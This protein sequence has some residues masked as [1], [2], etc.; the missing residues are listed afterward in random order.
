MK[1]YEKAQLTVL[2]IIQSNNI[3]NISVDDYLT[4]N[5]RDKSDIQ[6]ATN[7]DITISYSANS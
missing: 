4:A 6:E 2:Q 5:G 7:Y 3:A 1:K